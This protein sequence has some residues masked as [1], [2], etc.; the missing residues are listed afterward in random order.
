MNKSEKAVEYKSR[1]NCCQAVLLAYADEL[2]LSPD[3]LIKL[4]VTFGSGMGG[5]EG[6]CGA[7][8]GAQ[9]VLGLKKYSGKPMGRDSRNLLNDLKTLC[10]S[11]VC[12]DIKG[13]ETGKILCSCEDCVANA[14]KILE[15][16]E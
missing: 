3:F 6:T 9:M 1:Y 16:M 7:L 4:G 14:V 15:N 10:G 2:N 8:V 5:M 12:K 13:I 11:T